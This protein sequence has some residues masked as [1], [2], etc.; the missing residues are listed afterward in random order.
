MPLNKRSFIEVSY[1]QTTTFLFSKRQDKFLVPVLIL[2]V[3]MKKHPKMFQ[4][5]FY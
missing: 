5:I 2:L 3:Y 4:L 1:Q